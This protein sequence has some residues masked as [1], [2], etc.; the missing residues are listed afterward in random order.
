MIWLAN[1]LMSIS[2]G[3]LISVVLIITINAAYNIYLMIRGS[4]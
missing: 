1:A 4:K 3:L 2:T